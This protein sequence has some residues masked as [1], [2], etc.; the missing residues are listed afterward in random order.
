MVAHAKAAGFVISA[1]DLQLAQ[2]E[3]S[4]EALESMAGGNDYCTNAASILPDFKMPA[5]VPV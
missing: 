4:E 2:E 3:I 1:E 5:T